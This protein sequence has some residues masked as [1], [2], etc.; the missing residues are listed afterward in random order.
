MNKRIFSLLLAVVIT[1]AALPPALAL[2][3]GLGEPLYE[4][5]RELMDG[6]YYTN[7]IYH[8]ASGKRVET[9]T[10]E[11]TPAGPV[12]PIVMAEDKIYSSMNVDEMVKYAESTGLNVH[13]AINADFFY[14][15][16]S[17]PL[18]GVIEAG[19]FITDMNGENMLAFDKD[20][21]F[22][23]R[24]PQVEMTLENH[25]GGE[26]VDS[27]TGETRSNAG[28]T[29]PVTHYNKIRTQT[30]GVF[31]YSDDYH[32]SS[33]NTNLPGWGVIFRVLEG[34]V[35]V[36]GE[37]S[38]EVEEVIPDGTDFRLDGEHMVLTAQ[39]SS[40]FPEEYL[41]FSVGDKVT[42]KTTCSDQRLT[43]AQWGTGCGDAIVLDG[44]ITDKD[45]WDQAL[46]GVHPRTV[47]GIK[48]DG[49]IVACVVD[50]RQSAYSN[51]ALLEEIAANMRARG[52]ETAV[53]L[54]G[55]ASSVM[56]VRLPGQESCGVVNRPSGGTLRKCSSYILF[57]SDAE[58][59]GPPDRLALTQDG[60]FVLA[61]SALPLIFT[62]VD[63]AGAPAEVPED[64]VVT[65]SLGAVSDG[66]YTAGE[67]GG[68]DVLTLWSPSLGIRGEGRVHVLTQVD[69][70]SVLDKNTGEA[71]V[72][73]DLQA[74]DSIEL[75]VAAQRLTRPVAADQALA[76]Y[77]VTEGLGTVADGVLT[78]TEG[79]VYEGVLTA[80][81]GG[82]SVE[83]PVTRE[84]PPVFP[85]TQGHWA[86][87]DIKLLYDNNV[88]SGYDDGNFYP[89]VPM[90]R[91]E[92]VTMLWRAASEPE[93]ED[94]ECT[95]NDIAPESWYYP[96]I[97]WAE[98]TG[99]S[100]GSGEGGFTPDGYLTREQ[101][102]TMLYRLLAA[103][104]MEL[105][106]ADR[107]SLD[108]FLDAGSVS[109]YAAD[110]ISSLIQSGLINGI[111][112]MLVPQGLLTRAQM[113]SLLVRALFS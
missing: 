23:S 95:F 75:N 103:L 99:I 26:Y 43:E 38:L 36:S 8:N 52:C 84:R 96:Q 67:R 69:S 62:A 37:V 10:L 93:A 77:S 42:L 72:L 112:D 111:D 47:V 70:I 33:T 105:P 61:G 49:S 20:G 24:A 85:D 44:E 21:A 113:A 13:A 9:F 12:Y 16:M 66:V 98:A 102:F 88:V 25:G 18:G 28:V 87:A 89:D 46:T 92:F 32:E 63:S 81:L 31:L 34:S 45:G 29:V 65:A 74:G 53:N 56:S 58:A 3:D 79:D 101:G 110:G 41:K 60:A 51:G 55:G 48:P 5:T 109:D 104:R 68:M 97:A 30:G 91:A 22:F 2:G 39:S 6:F 4:N 71:P 54:D 64:I 14:N 80:A 106:A 73:S 59:G 94:F 108:A 35:T 40:L 7:T 76:E 82:Q 27:E 78:V 83:L 107:G 11:T 17:M 100:H 19:E 90:T 86:E 1:A 57:V 50:G 15:S